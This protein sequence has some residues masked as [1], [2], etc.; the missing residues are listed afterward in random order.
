MGDRLGPY[1][2]KRDFGATP[3]PPP[4]ERE[5][6]D[7]RPAP[8]FVVQE[9]H[10]RA[11][12]WDL[13][14]EHEGTL[15]V[16][17]DPEGHPGRPEA[18]QPRR[19]HGGPPARVPRLRGRHPGGRVRRRQ[20][21]DLGP[22]DL[23]AAQVPRQ[24]GDGHLPRRAPARPL[25]PVPHGREQLDDP[26]DGP[27]GGPGPGADAARRQAD[28]G[29]HRRRS[30]ARTGAGRTRSSGT[31]CAR[32]ATRRAAGCGWRAATASDIT[33]R[34]PELRDLGRAL[35]SREAVL[36]GEVV[37]F[38]PDGRP[39]FQR[40]QRRMHLTSD[41]LVRR[42]ARTEPVAYVIFDLLWLDGHSLMG[43]AYAERRERLLE[44]G[45]ERADVADPGAPRR[46][47]RGAA[48]GDARA[49]PGGHHRQ[50]ARRPVRARAG[51]R[52]AG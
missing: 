7:E 24:G 43:E 50:A 31:G 10:A 36:D 6:A 17:G 48:G 45:P 41:S 13:R 21:A 1:R 26:P 38:G 39:S 5:S 3:E 20:D 9:H 8:R 33:P 4:G 22:R 40:L 52:R 2:A 47:R 25:R 44:L 51:A 23:R 28:A 42:L 49:G 37:A 29:A 11:M 16:V 12:H 46:R 14:L 35:G 27:A 34:Y 19:P 18:Q 30:R 15:A 32:S